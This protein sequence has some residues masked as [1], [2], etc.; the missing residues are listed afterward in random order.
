MTTVG[1]NGSFEDNL[2]SWYSWFGG[3]LTMRGEIIREAKRFG[4]Q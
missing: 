4:C 3:V 2:R 1:G